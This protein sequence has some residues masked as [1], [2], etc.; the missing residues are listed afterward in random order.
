MNIIFY[1]RKIGKMRIFCSSTAYKE[2]KHM[3]DIE[4]NNFKSTLWAGYSFLTEFPIKIHSLSGRNAPF[5]P[6]IFPL[7]SLK[8]EFFLDDIFG[9][10]LLS[11]VV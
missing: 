2:G 9:A 1:L 3:L 10:F 11:S 8:C 5:L 6:W 7:I 4:R